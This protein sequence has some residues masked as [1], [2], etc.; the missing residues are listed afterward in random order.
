M[1]LESLFK[2]PIAF[3]V[4][5][6]VLLSLGVVV[7][8]QTSNDIESI[9]LATGSSSET[10][11]TDNGTTTTLTVP[12]SGTITSLTATAKNNSWLSFDGVNDMVNYLTAGPKLYQQ[13]NW[14]Y[15]TWVNFTGSRNQQDWIIYT[16][17][18]GR[19]ELSTYNGL[20]YAGFYNLTNGQVN[21]THSDINDSSWHFVS[22][23]LDW[24]TGQDN[25]N[26]TLWVDGNLVNSIT[27]TAFNQSMGIGL[28]SNAGTHSYKGYI[29]EVRMYNRTLSQSEITEIYN[30][31]LVANSSLPTDGLVLWLPLNEGSG[32]TVHS[33]NQSDFT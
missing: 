7:I 30:S 12:N 5:F 16:G 17:T 19:I 9:D 18:I 2:S 25:S 3:I 11:L 22:F 4:I 14:T 6:I 27:F 15:T 31:G 1:E 26:G 23:M 20:L 28:S 10:L 32:T 8:T 33:F 24:K 21:I 29:D 13:S